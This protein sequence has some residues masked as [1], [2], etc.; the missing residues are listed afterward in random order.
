[1]SVYSQGRLVSNDF[2]K[3]DNLSKNWESVSLD[4]R[5]LYSNAK[6]GKFLKN[7]SGNYAVLD[8]GEDISVRV[9]D[10]EIYRSFLGVLSE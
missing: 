5:S 4:Y 1:M 9:E 7:I 8:D 6:V 2:V 3:S 10:S